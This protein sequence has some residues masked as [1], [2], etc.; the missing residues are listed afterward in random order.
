MLGVGHGA[1]D[2]RKVDRSGDRVEPLQPVEGRAIAPA[3][4]ILQR[5]GRE[6]QA[7]R[8]LLGLCFDPWNRVDV[9][10]EARGLVVQDDPK[11]LRAEIRTRLQKQF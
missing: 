1:I 11:A 2:I 7:R 5:G 10:Q 3:E 8:D 4:V 6:E 9:E